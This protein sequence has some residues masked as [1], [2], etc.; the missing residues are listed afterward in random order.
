MKFLKYVLVFF[1]IVDVLIF[2]ISQINPELLVEFL[3]QFNLESVDNTYPRLVGFFFLTLGLSRLYGGLYIKEKGAFVVSMWS[4]IV[5]LIYTISEIIHG[6][7][8]V[9]EN[10][11]ALVL[12]PLMLLWSYMYFK[13]TF[14]HH[15]TH[16]AA[17]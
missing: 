17:S 14:K 11:M 15:T 2:L 3:P 6:Q 8:T 4:W 1:F 13:R 7:F 5:E 16:S 10:I 12:A 9:N